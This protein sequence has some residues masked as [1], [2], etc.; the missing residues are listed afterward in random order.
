MPRRE[1][2]AP[3]SPQTACTL[4]PHQ[5]RIPP[6]SLPVGDL[7]SAASLFRQTDQWVVELFSHMCQSYNQ[8]GVKILPYQCEVHY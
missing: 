3:R 1:V 5:P 7:L 2:H 8:S 4:I 6:F